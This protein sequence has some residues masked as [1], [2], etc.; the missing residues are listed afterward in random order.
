MR[1]V[2][3]GYLQLE[4]RFAE[5]AQ[6]QTAI[7]AVIIVGSR[8][9]TDHPADEWSD[10]DL[11]AFAGE[12]ASYLHDPAWLNTFGDVI[13]AISD[14]FGQHDREWV[15]LYAGGCKLDVAFL[16]IDPAATP[17]LQAM[18][19][20]FPYPNVLERGVRI[21]VD[22]TAPGPSQLLR[23]PIPT[24][25]SLPT[26]DEFTEAIGHMLLDAV[27]TAKFIRRHD[28]WRAKHM[29]DG[30]LKQQLLKM[31][32]WHAATQP[33]Q[34]DIWYDGRYLDEW[35]DRRALS[36][37]PQT[38][39][40]YQVDDLR[41]ALL[42]THLLYRWLAQETAQQQGYLYPFEVDEKL[43]QYLQSILLEEQLPS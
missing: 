2:S 5:W 4:Q 6:T 41:R 7:H 42:A 24:A 19:D 3:Q 25:L 39:A 37:L 14:S 11:V 38:F 36:L 33:A 31:L 35:A 21:L 9:R 28:L 15:A 12:A 17:T 27:K 32:E 34:R 20:V 13:A 43:E 40:A 26:E 10:L 1:T 22:K 30:E 8:A 29:C 23:L 18:L 16:S